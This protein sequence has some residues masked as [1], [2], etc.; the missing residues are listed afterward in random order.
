MSE[1][2]D[3][4]KIME[5][6]KKQS[7]SH[8]SNSDMTPENI[9]S[10]ASSKYREKLTQLDSENLERIR[11]LD[12]IVSKAQNENN[13]DVNNED[14]GEN[15]IQANLSYDIQTINKIETFKPKLIRKWVLKFR[16]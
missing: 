12:S 2:D 1:N 5:H 6:I 16:N 3:V 7:Q 9:I 10:L 8:T 11:E 13:L 14:F 4:T 15:L